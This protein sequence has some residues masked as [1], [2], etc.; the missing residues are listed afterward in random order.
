MIFSFFMIGID[1]ASVV[2]TTTAVTS[3]Q[4]NIHQRYYSG[5]GTVKSYYETNKRLY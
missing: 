4:N 5:A 1:A 2:T 3:S